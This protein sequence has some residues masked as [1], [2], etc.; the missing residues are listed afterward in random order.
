MSVIM[1]REVEKRRTVELFESCGPRVVTRKQYEDIVAAQREKKLKFEYCLGYVIEERF[2]AIAPVGLRSEIEELGIDIVSAETFAKAVNEE[3]SDI[4]K[5]AESDIH[6]LYVEGKLKA[7]YYEEDIEGFETLISN[8]KEQRLSDKE[9]LKLVDKL[10]VSG[11][12]LYVCDELPEWKDYIDKYDEY[13]F[14]DEDERFRYSYAI[15]EDCPKVWLD[16]QGYYKKPTK[17]S[18]WI[19][20]GTELH[21]GLIN[22]NDKA[23]K[24]IQAVGAELRDKLDTAEQNI[25]LFLAVKVILDAAAD[26]VDLDV[27]GDKGMLANPSSPTLFLIIF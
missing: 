21:L 15:L 5:Q 1:Y 8:W 7:V 6:R 26:A 16:E 22:K 27:P 12:E 18:E 17:P 19:T 10:F 20:R 25:R 23:K 2:Y 3:Y 13:L 14:G 9:M 4:F 24:S 11:Q